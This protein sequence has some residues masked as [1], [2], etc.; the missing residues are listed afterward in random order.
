[1]S[2]QGPR[3]HWDRAYGGADPAGVSWYQGEAQPSRELIERFGPGPGAA[4]ID[5]GAG[6]SPLVDELLAEGYRDLTVLDVSDRA[7]EITRARLGSRAEDVTFLAA[8]LATWAPPR[9]WDVWHDRAVMHFLVDEDD[10]R[11]Y[12][13][14]LLVGTAPGGVAIIGTFAPDG[15]ERCS[16]LPV[17]RWSPEGL[18]EFLSPSFRLLHHRRHLHHT[19]KGVA[20]QFQFSVLHRT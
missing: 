7:L 12:R 15:P 1:M 16:G 18:A 4:V 2:G 3:A 17:R 11:A 19:P 10:Q 13:G 5:I 9:R 20:Q 6:T 8:D 14:A